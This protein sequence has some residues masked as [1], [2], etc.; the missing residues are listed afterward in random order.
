MYLNSA[1]GYGGGGI[2]NFDSAILNINTG[3]QIFSNNSSSFGGGILC[4]GNVTISDNSQI[5]GNTATNNGGGIYMDG[6]TLT[7]NGGQLVVNWPARDQ[8]VRMTGPVVL[9][10][11]GEIDTASL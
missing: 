7:M 9:V 4:N 6:G 5:Y 1:T 8:F 2:Y 10:Y 3:S 11:K